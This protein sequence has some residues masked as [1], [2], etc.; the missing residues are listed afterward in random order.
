MNR[1]DEIKKEIISAIGDK[2]NKSVI[3]EIDSMSVT[4]NLDGK[5]IL[6]KFYNMWKSAKEKNVVGA[7]NKV[8]SHTAYLLGMTTKEPDEEDFIPVR[9]CFARKGFPDIDSDF[10]DENRDEIYSYII[11]KYGRDNVGNIGTY[12][13]I[14]LKSYI[15][16]IFKALDPD[17]SFSYT[18]ASHENKSV[19]AENKDKWKKYTNEKGDEIAK[20]LPKQIGANIRV[21]DEEGN[22][23]VIKTVADG[24]KYCDDFRYY[25]EKYPDLLTY[26]S[27]IQG[28]L[29]NFSVHAAGI[30]ISSVPLQSIAPLRLSRK[31]IEN[32]G[33]KNRKTEYELATQY[34]N[35]DLE[36]M[37]LIK[38]DILA[39][40]TL[41][42]IK[43]CV[44]LVKN[45]YDIDIDV[46]N[47]NLNDKKTF[48]LYKSGQL[49]GVFQCE[50]HGMQH[51]MKDIKVDRFNDIIAGIALYRPGPMKSIPRY[52]ACKNGEEPISYFHDSIE[53][54]VKKYLSETYGNLVYQEQVMQ[55][56][57][58]LAG[59]SITDG[60]AMI[61]AVGKKIPELMSKYRMQFIGGCKA[62]KV[63]EEVAIQYWDKFITPFADYGFNKCLLG[64]TKVY[65]KISKNKISLE[66]LEQKFRLEKE[67]NIVLDSWVNGITVEDQVIDVFSTGDKE[68]FEIEFDNGAKISCTLNHKFLCSDGEFR[69]VKDIFEGGYE[70]ILEDTEEIY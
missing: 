58:S 10:D 12:Q 46:E 38:F 5:P 41:S 27:D 16:S 35:E 33:K 21:T 18:L 45:N 17:K 60:Y 34:A 54:Y 3:S 70:I 36:F 6:F 47:L 66:S 57:N 61:K 14:K 37:G 67:H 69:E 4:D 19:R 48:D 43:N 32:G 20:S 26:S 25:I 28:L 30:V 42:V 8:N 7:T 44:K 68:V 65:D 50:N 55:I 40:S 24:A 39:I 13:S 23:V 63:P 56:C 22:D 59:F 53:P 51:T 49:N 2:I 31:K 29:S 9:R 52:V 15:R 62:K 11:E 1:I 64:S